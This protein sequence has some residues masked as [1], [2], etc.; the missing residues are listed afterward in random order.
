MLSRPHKEERFLY[1]IYPILALAAGFALELLCDAFC[2]V[3]QNKIHTLTHGGISRAHVLETAKTWLVRV[4]IAAAFVLG[5]SRTASNYTNYSGYM[6]VWK[7]LAK[8]Y[9]Q[10]VLPS[11]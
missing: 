6:A 4:F 5:V 1:P 8:R 11:W 9:H 2:G 10:A 3:V 7:E